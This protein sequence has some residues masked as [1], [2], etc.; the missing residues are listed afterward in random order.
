MKNITFILLGIFFCM[1]VLV[2]GQIIGDEIITTDSASSVTINDTTHVSVSSDAPYINAF[3][4]S[5]CTDGIVY[6][7]GSTRADSMFYS[8]DL[9]LVVSQYTGVPAIIELNLSLPDYGSYGT[10]LVSAQCPDVNTGEQYSANVVMSRNSILEGMATSTSA[11]PT[12]RSMS[13]GLALIIVTVFVIFFG[14]IFNRFTA[15]LFK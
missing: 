10:Y 15:P 11:D 9:T 14:F 12:I 3:F 6:V 4:N 8:S 2:F 5:T 1:P 13:W 7:F